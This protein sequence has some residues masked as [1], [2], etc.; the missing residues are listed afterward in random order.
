MPPSP[1]RRPLRTKQKVD[2]PTRR[3][4]IKTKQ[5]GASRKTA[6]RE[7]EKASEERVVEKAG[8]A[9]DEEMLVEVKKQKSSSSKT[10]P[11]PQETARPEKKAA[12]PEKE[13]APRE[14][15]TASSSY[16][17]R[18]AASDSKYFHKRTAWLVTYPDGEPDRDK[19]TQELTKM[20]RRKNSP[21]AENTIRWKGS[22]GVL[23]FTRPVQCGNAL[24]MAR[25]ILEKAIPPQ[26]FHWDKVDIDFLQG[27]RPSDGF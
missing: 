23:E 9:S 24:N 3:P 10:A 12:P 1:T 11:P 20:R 4:V 27:Q 13:T 8:A 6:P 5:K 2:S 17:K 22:L 14:K 18:K 25:N 7:K 16:K 21:L 15:E 26:D 19:V